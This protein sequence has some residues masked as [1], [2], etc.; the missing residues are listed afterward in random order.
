[1]KKKILIISLIFS[2]LLLII[3]AG[4]F[5]YWAI[6]TY[7]AHATFE[8]YCNWRGL[9]VINQSSNFGY[10]KDVSGQ[11]YKIVLFNGRWYLDGDLP[12]NWPF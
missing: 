2:I 3:I 8:G 6:T 11:V 1:M 7:Q 5:I 9:E 10:C 12:N 4:L